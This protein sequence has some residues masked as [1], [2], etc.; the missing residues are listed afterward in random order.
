MTEFEKRCAELK[1]KLVDD[2]ET[3]SK[4]AFEKQEK[5]VLSTMTPEEI[6]LFTVPAYTVIGRSELTEEQKKRAEEMVQSTAKALGIDRKEFRKIRHRKET[7]PD[8]TSRIYAEIYDEETQE[9]I[10]QEKV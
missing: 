1:K 2:R 6:Q 10:R 3:M 7:L 9:W 4:E 8:G 5:E